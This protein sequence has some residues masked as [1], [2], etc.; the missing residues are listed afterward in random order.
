MKNRILIVATTPY[1]VRQFLMNNIKI[2]QEFGYQIEIATNFKSFNVLNDETLNAFRK[3]LNTMGIRI[4]Q[5][6]FTRSIVD[7]K[8]AIKSYLQMRRLLKSRNYVL[9][10]THTP[11][12]SVISRFASI[13]H[14]KNGLKIIYTAHGFHFYKG[15]PIK[16]WLFF[17]LIE[18]YLSYYTD[19]LITIN[20]EDYN[21][22]NNKFKMSRLEFI[23]GVGVDINK[24]KLS[25]FNR[26]AYRDKLGINRENFVLLS[27]G[28]L[29]KN[30]N[31]EVIIKAIGKLS[32][33]NIKYLIVG[34]GHLDK[35]LKKL[36]FK[37]ELQDNVKLL[38][39]R[40]D[41]PYLLKCSDLYVFPSKR[42]G[43][44]VALMEAMAAGLPCIVSNIR[45]NS[46]LIKIDKGGDLCNPCD[47]NAF[48]DSISRLMQDK[49]RLEFM[50][51]FNEQA[52]LNYD[53]KKIDDSIIGIYSTLLK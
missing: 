10:H 21:L 2:L 31:H 18:K 34:S 12:A 22:A 43:L 38:G 48:K 14:K 47:V 9:M 26:Q 33:S 49:E 44:S 5:I 52:I 13:K 4:N 29:N 53:T 32:D 36:I 23:P 19:V 11:I 27:V 3:E 46:D 17:Y 41:I 25:N 42:E 39:F 51:R 8:G 40:S 35:Y 16:N 20:K 28:E 45:G 15:A 50:G 1:M 7:M 6:D 24:F 37:L 30:K